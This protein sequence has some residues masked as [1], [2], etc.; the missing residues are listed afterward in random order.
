MSWSGRGVTNGTS[1]PSPRSF[2]MNASPA[3][4]IAEGATGSIWSGCSAG[5][6]MRPTCQSCMNIR[7]PASCTASD[8]RR[9]PSICS[10]LWIPGVQA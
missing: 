1:S 4:R 10:R 2:S 8:T 7:P 5:C 9:Q 3:G 6:E